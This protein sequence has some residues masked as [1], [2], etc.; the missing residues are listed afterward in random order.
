MHIQLDPMAIIFAKYICF[1]LSKTVKSAEF[2]HL[3]RLLSIFCWRFVQALVLQ[4]LI[5]RVQMVQLLKF[6]VCIILPLA[7]PQGFEAT[8]LSNFEQVHPQVQEFPVCLP[9]A[10]GMLEWPDDQP[11]LLVVHKVSPQVI[12]HDGILLTV[13]LWELSPQKRQ[14]LAV[15]QSCRAQRPE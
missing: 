1:S 15:K 4:D 6:L 13:V 9:G 3:P 11:T 12:H 7:V 8:Q 10:M 5:A 14:G 2:N